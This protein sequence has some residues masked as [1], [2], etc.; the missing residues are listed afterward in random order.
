MRTDRS[1][2]D[3][4]TVIPT[5]SP[6]PNQAPRPHRPRRTVAARDAALQWSQ[7]PALTVQPRPVAELA[8]ADRNA[9]RHS[10]KQ[11]QQLAAS[12]R[13][14]GFVNPILVDP[15][16]EVVAG[17]GRLA[18]AKQLGLERV[19]TIRIDHL[20]EDQLRAYRIADNRL[21]ELADWDEKLLALELQDLSDLELSFDLELVGFATEEIDD[22]IAGLDGLDDDEVADETPQ[23]QA[24]AVTRQGDLWILGPHRVLCAD[25]RDPVAYDRLLGAEQVQIGIS[26]PPYNVRINGHV[27]GLGKTV[28]REFAMASG[29][30]SRN[31]F[32]AFLRSVL[33]NMAAVSRDGAMHFIFMDWCHAYDLLQAGHEVYSDLKNICIWKKSNAGMGSLWRSHHEMIFVWKHGKGPHINNIKLGESGRYRT[34]VWEYAGVNTFRRGRAEELA[35]HPTVKPVAL[36]MDAIKD[37]S[38]RGGIVL[39]AFGSGTTLIAAHRTGR[40]ACLLEFDPLYVDVII[41]R[42]QA[43]IGEQARHAESGQTLA[44]RAQALETR[45]S[46]EALS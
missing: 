6:D 15:R 42:W 13:Q 36:V 8:P 9:R 28:H 34:N 22:L 25:A 41:R 32:V 18:A 11:V 5:S 4:L 16:G 33:A 37:C 38:H 31:E 24:K 2:L 21:A 44:E 43:L 23:P 40:A 29:E 45:A 46:G 26:D 19:P 10:P 17:H 1:T 14:F 27:C 30:M 35:M 3:A 12:I 7:H 39:D 20:T